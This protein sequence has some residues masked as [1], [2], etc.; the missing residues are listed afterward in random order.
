[1]ITGILLAITSLLGLFFFNKSKSAGALLDNQ[2]TKEDLNRKDVEKYKNDGLLQA[3]EEKRKETTTNA[4]EEK[5][6]PSSNDEL[7]D[8][9]NKK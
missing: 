8:F 3:E 9:F 6:K 5:A 1:M 4:E 7:A 2:A